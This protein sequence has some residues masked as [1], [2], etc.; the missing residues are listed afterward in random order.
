MFSVLAWNSIVASTDSIH[1]SCGSVVDQFGDHLLGC[2]HGPMRIRQHDA[3]CD[4]VFHAL[5][6]DNSGC[7]REQRCGSS[8]DRPGDVNHPDFLYGKPAYLDVTVCNP[9]QD[10]I[11]SQSAVTAGVAAS[12]GEVEKDAHHEEAVLGAGGIFI[13]LAVETLGLW[14]PA[15]LR[16]LREIAVRTTNRSGASTALACCHFIEQLSTCLWRHNSRLF[17]YLFSLLPVSPLWELSPEVDSPTHGFSHSE[18][19]GL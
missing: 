17:L 11:L 8:L 9:L 16:T 19:L 6:Q 3:L 10:S 2:G 15:S 4:V 18:P 13:P 7:K 14:S 1:C 12:W 5:L